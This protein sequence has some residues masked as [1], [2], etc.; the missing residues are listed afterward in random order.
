MRYPSHTPHRNIGPDGK[1]CSR[2]AYAA[3]RREDRRSFLDSVRLGKRLAGRGRADVRNNTKVALALWGMVRA[4]TVV[5][6]QN[7]DTEGMK[8]VLDYGRKVAQNFSNGGR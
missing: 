3:A 7:G 8:S 4:V 6:A 5:A 2:A 1:P